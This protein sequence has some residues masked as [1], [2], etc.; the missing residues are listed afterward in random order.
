MFRSVGEYLYYKNS[1]FY[2]NVT[3]CTESDC[4]T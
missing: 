4:N 1:V 2:R 3:F